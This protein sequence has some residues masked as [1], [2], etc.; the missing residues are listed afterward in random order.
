[1][2]NNDLPLIVAEMLIEIQQLKSRVSL[3]EDSFFEVRDGLLDI[4][5][6][7]QET[8]QEILGQSERLNQMLTK[9]QAV[10]QERPPAAAPGPAAESK[11]L[12]RESEPE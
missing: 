3:L 6:N 10:L 11:P 5:G 12:D 8:H 1:M 7:V 4:R 9:V 2:D